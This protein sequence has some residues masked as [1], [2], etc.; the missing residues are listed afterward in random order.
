MVRKYDVP[1]AVFDSPEV[2]K[3]AKAACLA[4]CRELDNTPR[5]LLDKGN[6]NHP[7]Y[8]LHIFGEHYSTFMARQF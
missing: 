6:P 2:T 4:A 1:Q 8:D 7:Q 5:H 3:L